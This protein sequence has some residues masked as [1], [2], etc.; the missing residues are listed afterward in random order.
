M[1]SY[2]NGVMLFSTN[3]KKVLS[4]IFQ[5]QNLSMKNGENNGLLAGVPF[6]SPSCA[7]HAQIPPSPSPLNA[8]HGGCSKFQVFF[9]KMGAK[10]QTLIRKYHLLCKWNKNK[11]SHSV[12]EWLP[13]IRDTAT[14]KLNW[15]R[16]RKQCLLPS[17]PPPSFSVSQNKNTPKQIASYTG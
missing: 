7:L 4:Q 1:F 11:L 3:R 16:N 8:C 13:F 14:W 15:G 9:F 17:P 6:L 2:S 10:A 5:A 12:L